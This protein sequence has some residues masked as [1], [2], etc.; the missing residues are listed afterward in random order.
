MRQLRS[1]FGTAL[2]LTCFGLLGCGSDDG[3]TTHPDAA[4]DAKSTPP[5]PDAPSTSSD[6]AVTPV[7]D[8]NPIQ[9]GVDA[10]PIA[11]VDM[12]VTVSEAG[13][14][15]DSGSSTSEAGLPSVDVGGL[16]D[17]AT[18]P[19][20]IRGIVA[21]H[22]DYQSA[23]I[24]LL[25]RDG[26]V[27]KDACFNS[28]T[29]GPGLLMALSGDVAL[30]SQLS[31]TSPITV[32]DRS[33]A[34]LTWIDPVTCAP[35]RQLAV[36]TGFKANPHDYVEISTSKAYV[37][38]YAQNAAPTAAAGDF[39]EGNDLLI[40]DPTQAKI[41]GRI[42]LAPFAPTGV[43]PRADR[44]LLVEGKVF[45]S[46]NASNAK[47]GANAT[48]RL[49]IVD[50]TLD[51]VVGTVDLPGT[52]NCGAMAYV[53]ASKKLLVACTGDYGDAKQAD[54]SAVVALN[55]GTNPPTVIGKVSA[56][57]VGGLIFSNSAVAALD[58]NSVL[59]VTMGDFSNTP[60][61]NLWLLP[62][63]GTAPSKVFSSTEAYSLGA[64]LVDVERSRVF[65]TDGTTLTSASVRVFDRVGGTFQ[66]TATIKTNPTQKLPAR[67]L[68]W[69]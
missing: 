27:V 58:G 37:T 66:A 57:A 26:T 8:A 41:T 38:R 16:P 17:T 12:G 25:D 50:P 24:S 1:R 61:D 63:D 43:L 28:G 21:A 10:G 2:F 9:P 54:A 45:V 22:S 39:D 64:V 48:G 34:A 55:V 18:A 31:P 19:L 36:G 53:P 52:K 3:T 20:V 23:S 51:Q 32:I 60:P 47:F 11:Q 65:A 6:V 4:V 13:V 14:A 59:G 56:S 49:V 69:F 67:A 40:V 46:L 5:S 15:L 42:D 7:V 33:Y 44:A 35:L 30:P 68:A 62:Q 29:G